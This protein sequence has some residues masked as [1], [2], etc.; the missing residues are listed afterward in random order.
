MFIFQKLRPF[1]WMC[2]CFGAFPFFIETFPETK[3]FK[4]FSFS[5]KHPVTWWFIFIVVIQIIFLITDLFRAWRDYYQESVLNSSLPT[6]FAIFILLE[7]LFFFMLVAATR[8]M[9]FLKYSHLYR[10]FCLIQKAENILCKEEDL[11]LNKASSVNRQ[12]FAGFILAM[13]SVSHI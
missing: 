4:K 3:I 5:W 2:Q 12:V 6:I 10:A 8:F 13:A 1:V 7:H 9:I 11:S